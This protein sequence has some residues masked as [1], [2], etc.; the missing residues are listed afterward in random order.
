MVNNIFFQSFFHLPFQ[1][2]K[3]FSLGIIV[4]SRLLKMLVDI[5]LYFKLISLGGVR[6]R[7]CCC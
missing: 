1:Y 7:D 3:S 2:K 6:W 5:V 4:E